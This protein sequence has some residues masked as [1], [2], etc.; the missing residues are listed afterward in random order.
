[1]THEDY[2]VVLSQ[3]DQVLGGGFFV[4]RSYVLTSAARLRGLGCGAP[5]DVRTAEGV[6]LRAG[7]AEV[8]DDV[9]LA[10]IGV[11]PDPRVDYA[12][13]GADRA[14]KGDPW[15]APFRPDI[16]ARFL[17]GTVDGVV[18]DRR[19]GDGR[20]VSVV[21]LA[22]AGPAVEYGDYAGGP[23]ERRTTGAE[24][25]VVGVV[26]DPERAVRL[27]EGAEEPLAA[28]AIDSAVG[29]FE[30]LSA[31]SL[32]GMLGALPQEAEAE[33]VPTVPPPVAVDHS[34]GTTRHVLREFK[35]MADE[36]LVDPA[37]VSPMQIRLM[38]WV[39]RTAQGEEAS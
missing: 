24:P 37:F 1:M 21:E 34:L 16:T 18:H 25:A 4:T 11:L 20:A 29:L 12:T 33:R 38:E 5:V 7:V 19:D 31:Q 23:V 36:G 3:G 30:T 9:G 10:L 22:S 28:C 27:R 35:D 17:S 26:L 15:H 32:L 6:L 39:V 2:W 14:V 13:P 8:A